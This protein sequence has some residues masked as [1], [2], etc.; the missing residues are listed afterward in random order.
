MLTGKPRAGKSTAIKRVIHRIGSEYFGG[1]YT[2]EIRNMT[3]RTGFN[4]VS[5]S[6]ESVLIA[7]VD[8]SSSLRV[9]RYGVDID[10]FE[11][12]ALKAVRQSLKT[13]KITVIDEI[14]FMQM[15][16]DPFQEMILDIMS[17][18]QHFILATICL[19]SHP[20]INKIKEK[21]GINLYYLNEENRESITEVL[22]NDIVKLTG[23]ST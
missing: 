2:E 17:S 9:G 6:G 16:S 3:D 20:V 5:L 19:D 11:N 14:G 13:K 21:S 8:S 7:S 18:S 1:F 12:I 23:T 10:A 22:A 15:L 4:C